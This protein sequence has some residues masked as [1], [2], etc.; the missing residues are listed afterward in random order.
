MIW[1]LIWPVIQKHYSVVT[2]LF[3][4]H[5][6]LNT[7]L[8]FITLSFFHAPK[9][10]RLNTTR[11]FIIKIPNRKNFKKLQLII[12][13]IMNLMNLRDYTKNIQQIHFRFYSL[14]LLFHQVMNCVFAGI[15]CKECWEETWLIIKSEIKNYSMTLTE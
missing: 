3:I 11:F 4:M 7:F 9:D 5:L 8:V 15:Y 12:N 6:T 14:M 13:L 2:E 10:V 1:F